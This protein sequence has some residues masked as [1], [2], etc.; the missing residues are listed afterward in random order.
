MET[1]REIDQAVVALTAEILKLAPLDE[2]ARTTG[3]ITLQNAISRLVVAITSQVHQAS[4]HMP[5]PVS[6]V[7][8]PAPTTADP[9]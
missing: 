4:T 6:E 8:L 5:A 2:A 7:V 1:N 3:S 9:I